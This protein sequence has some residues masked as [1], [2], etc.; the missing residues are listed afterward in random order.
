[1]F[2]SLLIAEVEAEPTLC[3]LVNLS[4]LNAQAVFEKKE[5]N[6]IKIHDNILILGPL[7]ISIVGNHQDSAEIPASFRSWDWL[8]CL[9]GWGI[10]LFATKQ[11]HF[12]KVA[13]NVENKSRAQLISS[14]TLFIN[15]LK[16]IV[17][18][19]LKQLKNNAGSIFQNL[20]LF[21][22]LMLSTLY[23][24]IFFFNKARDW[25]FRRLVI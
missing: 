4:I 15:P 6:W 2:R 8:L 25:S 13:H 22:H 5:V 24:S 18:W 1:M 20:N 3:W 21:A 10:K 7:S 9:K 14:T 11:M 19:L 23:K 16:Q 17:S 12:P